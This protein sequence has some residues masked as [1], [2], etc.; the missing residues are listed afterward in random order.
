MQQGESRNTAL[1]LQ[2]NNIQTAQ[3]TLNEVLIRGNKG[4]LGW[5]FEGTG[6]LAGYTGAFQKFLQQHDEREVRK[7][8]FLF[9]R[10]LMIRPDAA[11]DPLFT[12]LFSVTRHHLTTIS[13]AVTRHFWALP[14]VLCIEGTLPNSVL[15][16]GAKLIVSSLDG[17]HTAELFT[18]PVTSAGQVAGHQRFFGLA[19]FNKPLFEREAL[20]GGQFCLLHPNSA[21]IP[22]H[23][24]LTKAAVEEDTL[25]R[26]L[27][28]YDEPERQT[29]REFVNATLCQIQDQVRTS[30][31]K[32]LIHNL[33]HYVTVK[34]TSLVDKSRPFGMNVE[35]VVPLGQEYVF[36]SGWIRDPLNHMEALTAISD[37]GFP[38]KLKEHLHFFNRLSVD[39]MYED[40]P[41]ADYTG[42][43]GFVAL[44]PIPAEQRTKFT[45][46]AELGTFRFESTLK[47]GMQFAINAPNQVHTPFSARDALLKQ[48]AP[49]AAGNQMAEDCVFQAVSVLQQQCMSNIQVKTTIGFGDSLAKPEVSVIIPLYRNLDYLRAQ[50]AHFSNDAFM[51]QCQILYVLDSPE[52]E[53]A[54]TTLLKDLSLLYR[55]PLELAVM[56]RNYGYAM[57][58]NAGAALSRAWHLLFLNSDTLPIQYGWLERMHDFYQQHDKIG[59]LGTKL[60]YEDGAIQH[61]GMYFTPAQGGKYQDRTFTLNKHYYKGYPASY[62]AAAESRPV[63]AVTGACLMIE[64]TRFVE[65]GKFPADYVIGDFEDSHLCLSCSRKGYQ[66]YYFADVELLH[67]E[68][69]SMSK[70]THYQPDSTFLY[71][72]LQHHRI[73]RHEIARQLQQEH[74]A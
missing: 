8:L 25:V 30:D 74:A 64:R 48:V 1:I 26:Y 17:V 40:S 5:R 13:G 12:A 62:P 66:N 63:P 61:A 55:L 19:V 23:G 70:H 72:A 24:E 32:T 69:Q 38:L 39:T 65:A 52:Q 56:Q 73:W 2:T 21:T 45:K 59:A 44:V 28:S 16:D 54:L 22:L 33:Q 31:I 68:R 15:Q 50:V 43:W 9:A 37:L 53:E 36:F 27:Q 3:G 71:N 20:M 46:V 7:V 57:A 14:N 41:Y 51:K 34:H 49:L 60:L 18:V 58:C 29:L 4:E 47:G 10:F 11:K 35:Q 6:K 67:F 42:A